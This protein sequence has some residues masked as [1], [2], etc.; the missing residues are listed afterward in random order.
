MRDG[1]HIHTPR[2]VLRPLCIWDLRFFLSLVGNDQTRR[3]LGGPVRGRKAIQHF[4]A[5]LARP[6]E[7]L[8]WL[9]ILGQSG[10]AIGLVEVGLHKDGED[11]EVSYQFLPEQWGNGYAG[12]AV[13]AVIKAATGLLGLSRLIAET[14]SANFAS[15]RLLER[16]GMVELKRVQRFGNEQ[17]IYVTPTITRPKADV[18]R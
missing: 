10:Q 7:E 3:Y 8:I 9:V 5:Y 16:S 14:Q 13:A 11:Y 1:K 17:T 2:L 18:H 6:A 4:R 15:C 12:E